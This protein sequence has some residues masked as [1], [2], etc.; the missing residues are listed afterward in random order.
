MNNF[1]IECYRDFFENKKILLGVSGSIA[2]FKA[3]DLVRGLRKCGAEVR[4]VLTENGERF[5]TPL[6]FEGIGATVHTS[7]W[8]AQAKAVNAH[9]DSSAA[10]EHIELARWAD[11][12]LIAPATAN[13]IAKLANGMANDLLTTEVL[14]LLPEKRNSVYLAPA[15]NPSMLSHPATLENFKKLK[16]YGYRVLDTEW[17]MHACGDEGY[18][19]LLEPVQ[20][21]EQLANAFCEHS[22][23]KTVLVSMGPT[24]SYL[25]PVRYLTNRSSG[26]MGAAL[27]FAAV[28][29]G[30]HVEIVTG[31]TQAPLPTLAKITRVTTTD[32]MA[33]AVLNAFAEADYLLS[34]AAVLDFEFVETSSQKLKKDAMGGDSFA[35]SGTIDILKNAGQVKQKHQFILGFA[36]ETEKLVESAR[37]KLKNKNCDAVFVNAVS[38]DPRTG[39]ARGFE[40][41]DNAGILVTAKAATEFKVQSKQSLAKE[42]L[43]AIRL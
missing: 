1:W 5:V 31:P 17:G 36:A 4:V 33:G 8:N 2:A 7:M 24:R 12:I 6:T 30:Y 38:D 11:A 10:I 9:A 32:E 22:N 25:D 41:D 34:T 3:I 16:S 39:L 15:M 19:R 13:V 35:V 18:G 20:I 28:K 43:K 37:K 14:A 42:I 21:I 29:K 26:K 27:A 23:G 40:T